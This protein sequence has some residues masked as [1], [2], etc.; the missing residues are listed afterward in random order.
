MP[1]ESNTDLSMGDNM[2]K[3]RYER[4]HRRTAAHPEAMSIMASANFD[5]VPSLADSLRAADEE[6]KRLE[7][8]LRRMDEMDPDEVES[9]EYQE[10]LRRLVE[11]RD[12]AQ[13]NAHN[14]HPE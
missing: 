4:R 1:L 8:S 11:L 10:T 5:A 3:D 14:A 9:S 13:R 12:L 6:I 7:E 2:S